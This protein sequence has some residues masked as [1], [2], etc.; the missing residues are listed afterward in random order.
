MPTEHQTSVKTNNTIRFF[1]SFDSDSYLYQSLLD[2]QQ[3]ASKRMSTDK[4]KQ[5]GE[6]KLKTIFAIPADE[7]SPSKLTVTES[8]YICFER[9]VAL[10]ALVL[11]SPLILFQ[12]IIIR[13]DSPGPALFLHARSNISV[14][15]LGSELE[16]KAYLKP[17]DAEEKFNPDKY[18]LSPK[19]F[20]FIKFRT[21]YVDADG[22]YDFSES[23]FNFS[24]YEFYDSTYYK[25]SKDLRVT[26]VG[27]W[28]RRTTID[29]LPNFWCVLIGD[30]RLVGPRPEHPQ[31]MPFYS[32]KLMKKFTVKP[33]ITGLAQ[34]SGR[35]S[36]GIN[37][38]IAYDIQYVENRTILLDLKILVKTLWFVLAKKGAF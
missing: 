5:E 9:G 4:K 11:S 28:L 17:P 21:M 15:C 19:L 33:G 29:E 14:P 32:E 23:E 30:M 16:N 38:Q 37:D 7:Y 34:T 2:Q 20:R 26:R 12:Y 31:I 3:A 10:F 25:D 8:L 1:G 18:Y 36:L 22:G 13:L 35:G 27:K 24:K 6:P